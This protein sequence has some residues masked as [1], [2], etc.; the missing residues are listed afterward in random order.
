MPVSFEDVTSIL[1]CVTSIVNRR[2]KN[3]SCEQ[4]ETLAASESTS[5][6]PR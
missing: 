1:R 4:R 5:T 3:A 2:K 6:S